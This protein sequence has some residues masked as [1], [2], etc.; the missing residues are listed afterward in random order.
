[1]I[2]ASRQNR[3][4]DAI[5]WDCPISGP[6]ARRA[7]VDYAEVCERARTWRDRMRIRCPHCHNPIEVLDDDPLSELD[8]PSCGSRFNLLSTEDTTT[9]N[10]GA[11]RRIGQFEL[12]EAVGIGHFGSVWKAR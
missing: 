10:D 5:P 6:V 11:T 4:S 3:P 1:M 12:L 2:D 9:W 7:T 8:C